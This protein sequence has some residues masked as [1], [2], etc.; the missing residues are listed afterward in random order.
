[1]QPLADAGARLLAVTSL[2]LYVPV[3]TLVFGEAQLDGNC[4]VV[5][6]R[7]LRQEFYGL[8]PPCPSSIRLRDNERQSV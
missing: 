7:R 3:L 2:D 1:M 8:P 6:L 5:S 4:A